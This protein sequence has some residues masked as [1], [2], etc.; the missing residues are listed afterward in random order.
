M[1]GHASFDTVLELLSAQPDLQ[2]VHVQY[3]P[4][5]PK[6]IVGVTL[7]RFDRSAQPVTGPVPEQP[8]AIA[9]ADDAVKSPLIGTVYLAASPQDKPFVH[10]GQHVT[11]GDTLC[12]VEAMKVFNKVR[13][14]RSGVV[15]RCCVQDG[16]VVEFDQPLMIIEAST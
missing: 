8:V 2:E 5:H 6:Q 12:I 3:H 10:V 4:E 7:K 9:V 11:E 14:P 13:A 1:T 15:T 16:E